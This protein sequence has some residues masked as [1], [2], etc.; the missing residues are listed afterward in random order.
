MAHCGLLLLVLPAKNRINDEDG[1]AWLAIVEVRQ[2]EFEFGHL[3]E[4]SISECWWLT[5]LL[6]EF[7][8]S[9]DRCKFACLVLQIGCELGVVKRATEPLL[10]GLSD[11]CEAVLDRLVAGLLLSFRSSGLSSFTNSLF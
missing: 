1:L 11:L 2:R 6:L 3:F 9:L 5:Q 8:F 7:E 10:D 4:V